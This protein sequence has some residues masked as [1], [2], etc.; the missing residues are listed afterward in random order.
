[1]GKSMVWGLEHG[2]FNN[3]GLPIAETGAIYAMYMGALV[4]MVARTSLNI[5]M[6]AMLF[7]KYPFRFGAGKSSRK[8]AYLLVFFVPVLW[9]LQWAYFGGFIAWQVIRTSL[10][11]CDIQRAD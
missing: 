4:W 2:L 8:L 6:F 10:N 11:P 9:L 3:Q 1:M 5:L 7:G